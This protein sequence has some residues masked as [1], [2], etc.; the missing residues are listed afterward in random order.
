[1]SMSS[2]MSSCIR[3]SLPDILSEKMTE[4]VGVHVKQALEMVCGRHN[5][6][7][8]EEWQLTQDRWQVSM[9]KTT[10]VSS[11]SSSKV[12][13]KTKASIN[14]AQGEES[15]KGK[16]PLPFN[17]IVDESLCQNIVVNNSLH[18]QCQRKRSGDDGEDFCKACITQTH[19]NNDTP[20][21]GKISD[22][23]NVTFPFEFVANNGDISCSLISVMDRLNITEERCREVA[24]SR[25]ETLDERHFVR[26]LE[27]DNRHLVG[28][29]ATKKKTAGAR[30]RP[31]K[32]DKLVELEDS[33]LF[34]SLQKTKTKT[35]TK[36]THVKQTKHAVKPDVESS[37]DEDEDEDEDEEEKTEYVIGDLI[38]N[39]LIESQAQKAKDKDKEAKDKEA[40][41][42]DAKDKEAKDKDAKSKAKEAEAQS[43]KDKEASIK[44]ASIK[45]KEKKEKEAKDK[46]AKDKEAKDKEAKDKKLMS[47]DESSEDD[48]ESENEDDNEDVMKNLTPVSIQGKDYQR[49]FNGSLYNE[50]LEH[51]G[52]YNFAT[53]SVMPLKNAE[54]IKEESSD[55]EVESSDEEG[56]EEEEE[57]EYE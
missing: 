56:D 47:D 20:L 8:E 23:V 57:E 17:G 3:E 2:K 12:V 27:R 34:A 33:H 35:K 40:K 22:R 39:S 4:V 11:V 24:L 51:I 52:F 21:Y 7:F 25:N 6:D 29:G 18:T 44:K 26:D 13:K 42:K 46:E 55:V 49:A 36:T 5:L 31:K 15:F 45:K 10:K 41:D 43:I 32:E 30:G 37:S 54:V 9:E 53:D 16:F 19:K 48:C 28:T 1:M 50:Q 38:Q 14:N